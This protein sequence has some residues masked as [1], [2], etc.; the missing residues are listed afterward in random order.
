MH[1]FLQQNIIIWVP[2]VFFNLLA[3]F[4]ATEKKKKGQC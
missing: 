1:G 4:V 3:K 2:S